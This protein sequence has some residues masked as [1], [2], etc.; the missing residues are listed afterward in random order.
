[1]KVNNDYFENIDMEEI[2][3]V[4]MTNSK[5]THFVRD[6]FRKE[7][8]KEKNISK[9]NTHKKSNQEKSKGF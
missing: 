3:G 9:K 4:L 7:H 6:S 2:E 8:L 5:Y 1:M